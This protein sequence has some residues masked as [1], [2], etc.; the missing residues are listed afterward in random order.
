MSDFLLMCIEFFKTGLFSVGG[1]LAT[2]PFL[3]DIST[4]H[5]D[6]FSLSDMADMLAVAESTPGPIGINMSTYV[7][8][9]SFGVLGGI[10]TTLSLVL[11][12]FI[13]I[14]IVSKFWEKY[15]TN[16]KVM[17]I[18]AALRATAI[19]LI[20]SAGVVVLK[21]ALLPAGSFSIVCLI[22]FFFI[23]ACTRISKIKNLHPILFILFAA[24]IGILLKL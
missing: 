4:K 22:L 20:F 24:V 23:F 8:F 5:P 13:V 1:G 3:H 10:C 18:F 15:K 17:K 6:W 9:H 2:L 11:P 16:E 19:G 7:G 21:T 14:L 12:S